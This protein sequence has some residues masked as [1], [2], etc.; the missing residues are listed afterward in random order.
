MVDGRHGNHGIPV[1]RRVV[2]VKGTEFAH[3]TNPNHNMEGN[4]ASERRLRGGT[5]MRTYVLAV[6]NPS[7]LCMNI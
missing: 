7:G 6:S 4:H 2:M 3:V 5:V 1:A